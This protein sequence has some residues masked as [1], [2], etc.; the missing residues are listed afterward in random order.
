MYTIS[1]LMPEQMVQSKAR[2]IITKAIKR[3][4]LNYLYYFIIHRRQRTIGACQ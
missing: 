1:I 4:R 2:P 3:I